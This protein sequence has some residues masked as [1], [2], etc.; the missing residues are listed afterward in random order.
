[1]CECVCMC[2]QTVCLFFTYLNMFIPPHPHVTMLF[3]VCHP[4]MK[5]TVRTELQ[6][7]KASGVSIKTLLCLYLAK[8]VYSGTSLQRDSEEQLDS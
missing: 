4:L 8:Q 2:V 6:Q 1:M 7:I 5:V 3:I